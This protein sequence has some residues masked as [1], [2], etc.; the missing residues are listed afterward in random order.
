MRSVAEHREAIL[1][2]VPAAEPVELELSACCGLV[3]CT[4]VV[5]RVDLPGFDNSA[6][7]GYAIRSADVA[8]ASEDRPE[9]LRVVGEVAA[10]GDAAGLVVGPGQAV[11]IMTGAMMPAG[12]DAVVMVERTDGGVD[13]VSVCDPVPAGRSIRPAGEDVRA[14]AVVIPLSA[15]RRPAPGPCNDR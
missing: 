9:V 13:Q 2:A 1:G 12:A 7:D 5:A 14:G 3:T 11:R 10:G 8:E 15:R 4:D 6:M